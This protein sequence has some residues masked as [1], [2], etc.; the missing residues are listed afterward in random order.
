MHRLPNVA[1]FAVNT[2]LFGTLPFSKIAALIKVAGFDWVEPTYIHSYLDFDDVKQFSAVQG[3]S[4]FQQASDAGLKIR[5]V[6]AHM[7]L[8]DNDSVEKMARRI[9]FA[10]AAQAGMVITN[11][12][13]TAKYAT[14]ADNLEQIQKL[15]EQGNVVVALENPGDGSGA[16][17]TNG[18]AGAAFINSLGFERIRFNYDVS[19]ALSY[20]KN[21]LDTALDAAQSISDACVVHLHFKDMRYWNGRLEFCAIGDGLVDYPAVLNAMA[22]TDRS[23]PASLEMPISFYR[24][25]QFLMQRR[26][27]PVSEAEMVEV[28]KRSKANL[29]QIVKKTGQL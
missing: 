7:D 24:N 13:S 11:A 2:L 20:A 18:R 10:Q 23:V 25:E 17:L 9:E 3:K 1:E 26:P 5:A 4:V 29:E 15:A 21:G 27:E 6:A 8:G 19:N 12:S 16:L 14:F 22:A 28:L